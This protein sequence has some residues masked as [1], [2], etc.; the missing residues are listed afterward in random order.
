MASSGRNLWSKKHS[1]VVLQ[2]ADLLHGLRRAL[3]VWRWRDMGRL[4]LSFPKGVVIASC[5]NCSFLIMR[6]I[7]FT[8]RFF[9][10][11]QMS[12]LLERVA[13]VKMDASDRHDVCGGVYDYMW[14]P[15]NF[16]AP[17]LIWCDWPVSFS[18]L[19]LHTPC[20]CFTSFVFSVVPWMSPSQ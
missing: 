6:L 19:Q 13:C 17:V 7:S 11:L 16:P 14:H 3:C 20:S 5:D 10:A 15:D 9:R 1:H 4:A 12:M 2:V 18:K 8:L